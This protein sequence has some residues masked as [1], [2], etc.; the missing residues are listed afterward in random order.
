[1]SATK[2][3][4]KS[5][6]H[7][8]TSPAKTRVSVK[9]RKVSRNN[10]KPSET[11]RVHDRALNGNLSNLRDSRSTNYVGEALPE[12]N[13]AEWLDLQSQLRGRPLTE[14]IFLSLL[15]QWALFGE[16]NGRNSII[17]RVEEGANSRV[18]EWLDKQGT[19][20]GAYHLLT[21]GGSSANIRVYRAIDDPKLKQVY[22]RN[23]KEPVSKQISSYLQEVVTEM[24]EEQK[25]YSMV[26][27]HGS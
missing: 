10:A 25:S 18:I 2:G 21:S 14:E 12:L 27:S 23:L 16:K 6:I 24:I 5:D 26:V 9:Q 3:G 17:I 15:Q 8:L 7:S 11:G 19:H 13:Q 22:R 20:M 4:L 1:M